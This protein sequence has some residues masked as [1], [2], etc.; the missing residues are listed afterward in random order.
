M[1][2]ESSFR[3][4]IISSSLAGALALLGGCGQQAPGEDLALAGTPQ[5][6]TQQQV[7]PTGGVCSPTGAHGK[8]ATASCATCHDCGGVLQFSSTG[9][10]V[11]A[12]QPLPTFDA[13]NKTCS[14]VGCHSVPAGT[15]T[16]WVYDWGSETLYPVSVPYG[17]GASQTTPSWYTTGGSACAACH[18]LP[19]NSYNWHSGYHGGSAAD[20]A[21]QLCHEDAVGSTAPGG[22]VTGVALSTATNCGPQRNQPCAAAHANGSLTVTP[23]WANYCY[24]CH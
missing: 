13:V 21:C 17:G 7:L 3:G 16:Y 12:G 20:N 22:V 1:K 14:S 9:P 5:A 15:F 6:L 2:I 4:F 10:A 11:A 18:P 24:G 8:H 23:K 19:A